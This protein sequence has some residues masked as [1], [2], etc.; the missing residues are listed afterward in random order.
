MAFV[1][2]DS[3]VAGHRPA[4]AVDGGEGARGLCRVPEVAQGTNPLRAQPPS[5]SPGA[6]TRSRSSASTAVSDCGAKVGASSASAAAVICRPPSDDPKTLRM[7]TPGIA[8]RNR[9]RTPG[10]VGATVADHGQ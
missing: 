5:P 4:D 1:E 9:S 8:A 10:N 7:R 3:A 6:S 2:D